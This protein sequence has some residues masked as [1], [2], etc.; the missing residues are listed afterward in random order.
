MEDVDLDIRGLSWSPHGERI[1]FSAKK[2]PTSGGKIWTTNADGSGAAIL[3]DG[4]ADGCDDGLDPSWSPDGKSLALIC[5][6]PNVVS[7]IAV[8][9]VATKRLTPVATVNFPD[10]LD[11]QMRWS[12][13][14]KTIAFQIQQYDPTNTF[15]T[16][17]LLATVAAD[18]STALRR[19]T[20]TDSRAAAPD[21][22]PDDS[23]IVFDEEGGDTGPWNLYTIAPDG[24]NLHQLTTLSTDASLR[25][26]SPRWDVAT[27]RI[28]LS[29]DTT[30]HDDFVIG[31]VDPATGTVTRL[32]V[33]GVRPEPRP[34]P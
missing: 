32:A 22:S 16:G 21:W 4:R 11:D 34:V 8:L 23:R 29:V 30:G 19:L 15:V 6:A 33:D 20:K 5:Y 27:N 3:Y 17:S 24:T 7:K 9:D 28:W 31:W 25:I 13:D 18:G 10:I 14:G 26:I 2:D 1:A 12:H